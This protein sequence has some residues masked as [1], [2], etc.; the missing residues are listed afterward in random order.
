MRSSRNC[1]KK[2]KRQVFN[3]RFL[4][5]YSK[6][7]CL[8]GKEY[9]LPDW[10]FDY[11]EGQIHKITVPGK[12]LYEKL[13]DMG[14]DF[15]IKYPVRNMDKWK[16]A[17]AFLPK[18]N[19]VIILMNFREAS[20]T[21]AYETLDRKQFFDGKYKC[22]MILPEEIKSVDRLIDNITNGKNT[23]KS[24]LNNSKLQLRSEILSK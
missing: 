15:K 24:L 23:F 12:R 14:V 18:H 16:F 22:L 7:I 21:P 4:E 6:N 13:T 11:R 20:T 5:T 10:V 1:H 17:D 19:L 8:D 9:D 2:F 3:E